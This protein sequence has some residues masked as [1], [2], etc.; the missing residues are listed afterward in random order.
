MMVISMEIL[1][2][3]FQMPVLRLSSSEIL[4]PQCQEV[5]P[6]KVE[7]Q[8]P[9]KTV[10]S[11][12]LLFLVVFLSEVVPL[13]LSVS[14]VSLVPVVPG[15]LG[16]LVVLLSVFVSVSVSLLLVVLPSG[17]LQKSTNTSC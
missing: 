8:L 17:A 10:G 9:S 11:S 6:R 15:L 7:S 4:T 13:V 5:R 1:V 12:D 16:S 14:L 3:I 2:T